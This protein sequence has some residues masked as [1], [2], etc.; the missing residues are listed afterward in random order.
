MASEINT[1]LDY[2]FATLLCW[3]I[4]VFVKIMS[5]YTVTDLWYET[6]EV[7]FQCNEN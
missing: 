3:V 6:S 5:R 1:C 2:G 7:S 4:V